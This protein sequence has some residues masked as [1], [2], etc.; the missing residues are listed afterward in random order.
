[1]S[2]V[3]YKKNCQNCCSIFRI[4]V[5]SKSAKFLDIVLLVEGQIL[6]WMCTL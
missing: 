2:I 1:M 4:F 6:S 3:S 5:Y